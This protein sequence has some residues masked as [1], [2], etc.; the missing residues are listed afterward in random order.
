MARTLVIGARPDNIL[1]EWVKIHSVGPRADDRGRDVR[2]P[3]KDE[4]DVEDIDQMFAYLKRWG[5][6]DELI[7]GAAVNWLEWIPQIIKSDFIRHSFQVNV[8]GFIE[9]VSAHEFLYPG[10]MKRIVGLSSD[11]ARTAMRGSLVYGTTKA[12]MNAAVKNMARELAPRCVVVGVA[13]G[14][15]D[16]TPMTRYIDRTLPKH[17]GWTPEFARE[18]ENGMRPMGPRRI[19][20][21]EVAE[22]IQFA[23]AGPEMLSGSIVEITGGR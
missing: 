1:M 4:L 11:A 17:R 7:Y 16:D 2:F 6:F 18:Y 10:H 3:Y 9:M 19:T 15:V 8:I 22:T 23:L 14:M 5:P 12:A 20:K 13:P 21:K